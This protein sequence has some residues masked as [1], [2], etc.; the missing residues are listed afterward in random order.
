[1]WNFV[2]KKI[3]VLCPYS[4]LRVLECCTE[5]LKSTNSTYL[6]LHLYEKIWIFFRAKSEKIQFFSLVK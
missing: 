6:V 5:I 2:Q 3:K 4:H 1:M